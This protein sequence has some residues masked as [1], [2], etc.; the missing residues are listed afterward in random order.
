MDA[1][2][3]YIRPQKTSPKF[4]TKWARLVGFSQ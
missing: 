3:A 4:D 2:V 1:I